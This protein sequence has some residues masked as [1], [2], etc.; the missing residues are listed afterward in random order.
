[1]PFRDALHA[2]YL[3]VMERAVRMDLNSGHLARGTYVAERAVEVEP[4]AEEI[5]TA[6]VGL[7][8]QQGAHAAAAEQYAHYA[9]SLRGL[10]EEPLPMSEL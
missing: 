7:Y 9:Q 10:G 2:S 8:K 5:R 4:D 6:L 1:M 3:R